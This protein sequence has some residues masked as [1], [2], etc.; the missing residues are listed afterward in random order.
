MCLAGQVAP[1]L[2]S[3]IYQLELTGGAWVYLLAAPYRA[4]V[5]THSQAGSQEGMAL[6]RPTGASLLQNRKPG[7][8]PRAC[9]DNDHHRA[10]SAACSGTSTGGGLG[11]PP[12]PFGLCPRLQYPSCP[13]P[14]QTQRAALHTSG[15]AQQA[16]HG[17]VTAQ[18]CRKT[19][20]G[21]GTE[22]WRCTK[23]VPCAKII[24][25]LR[26]MHSKPRGFTSSVLLRPEAAAKCHH[27]QSV[28]PFSLAPTT[29]PQIT[30]VFQRT[31]SL[32][33]AEAYV[34]VGWA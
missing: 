9:R 2:S 4:L 15:R 29:T 34:G 7:G 18:E 26:D 13:Q 24:M 31:K 11:Q 22:A 8:Q 19:V 17:G 1:S 5:A 23:N 12:C 28:S 10:G 32:P 16:T 21:P 30:S 14:S 3:L 27:W 33:R 25:H 6:L 20:W